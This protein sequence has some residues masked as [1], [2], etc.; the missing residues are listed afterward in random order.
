M[1]K[2]DNS[3]WATRH[4]LMDM[5]ALGCYNVSDKNGITEWIEKLPCDEVNNLAESLILSETDNDNKQILEENY[6]RDITKEKEPTIINEYDWSERR[7][8]VL[9]TEA[10]DSSQPIDVMKILKYGGAAAAATY[11]VKVWADNP[12]KAELEMTNLKKGSAKLYDQVA[13]RANLLI[14]NIRGHR[15]PNTKKWVNGTG[16]PFPRVEKYSKDLQRVSNIQKKLKDATYGSG[17]NLKPKSQSEINSLRKQVEKAKDVAGKRFGETL[18]KTGNKLIDTAKFS[19]KVLLWT[20]GITGL[21]I[22][23]YHLYKFLF[24]KAA[25]SC[26]KT[27]GKQRQICILKCKIIACDVVI[28]KQKEALSGCSKYKNPERCI[29]SIQSHIWYW[30]HKKQQ[31]LTKLTAISSGHPDVPLAVTHPEHVEK[32]PEETGIFKSKTV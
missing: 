9:L 23:L 4:A 16:S 3:C 29:H 17:D 2:K 26:K 11:R 22:G 12:E 19:S 6:L 13:D 1:N 8:K 5:T 10:E 14:N 25:L 18:K 31:Y 24:S 28:E 15:D 32:K 20:T 30:E 27:H 7:N 21:S